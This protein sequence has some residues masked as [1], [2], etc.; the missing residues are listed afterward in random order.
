MR[1]LL[2]APWL[3]LC[4]SALSALGQSDS[5]VQLTSYTVKGTGTSWWTPAQ[6]ACDWK[7]SGNTYQAHLSRQAVS[8]P[9]G[10]DNCG[11]LDITGFNFSIPAYAK[12]TGVEVIYKATTDTYDLSV[13]VTAYLVLSSDYI[14]SGRSDAVRN[15]VDTFWQGDSTD[16]WK[17]DPALRASDVNRDSF[18]VRLVVGKDNLPPSALDQPKETISIYKDVSVYVTYQVQQ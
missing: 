18:G 11:P 14:S 7:V 8:S 12:I 1:L 6:F 5:Q 16:L 4:S 15:G 2:I 9:S 3:C 10:E 13:P 17:S